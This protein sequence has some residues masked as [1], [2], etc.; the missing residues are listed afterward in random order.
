M[1]AELK[2]RYGYNKIRFKKTKRHTGLFLGMLRWNRSWQSY[3]DV[4]DSAWMSDKIAQKYKLKAT[5]TLTYTQSNIVSGGGSYVKKTFTNI[6]LNALANRFSVDI[7]NMG[8]VNCD[9]FYNDNRPKVNFYVDLKDTA[10]NYYTVLVFDKI[11][12]MVRGYASGSKVQFMGVPKGESA[13]VICVGIQNGKPV[14]AMQSL[15]AEGTTITDLKFEETN[16]Y[17]FR[18]QAAGLDK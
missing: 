11:R 16:P 8:W 18:E 6:N 7:R 13:K 17:A 15:P 12:S 2:E 4:G 3:G 5:D 9:R 14:A 10:I 1:E